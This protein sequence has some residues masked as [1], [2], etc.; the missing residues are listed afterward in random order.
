MGKPLKKR[1]CSST[2]GSRLMSCAECN[3][4][5]PAM[6][7]LCLQQDFTH[8]KISLDPRIIFWYSDPYSK[9]F[10]AT[11]L[12]TNS[13][14]SSCYVYSIYSFNLQ[15]VHFKSQILKNSLSVYLFLCAHTGSSNHSEASVAELSVLHSGEFLSVIRLE[16]KRIKFNIT[17]VV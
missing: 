7:I 15:L 14:S 4:H 6:S 1:I 8:A 10:C 13:G 5:V 9:M 12:Q 3:G 11:V 2:K 17:W 16:S